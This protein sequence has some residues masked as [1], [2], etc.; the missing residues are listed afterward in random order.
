[1]DLSKTLLI[2]A[3]SAHK[4][5]VSFLCICFL[6]RSTETF[7]KEDDLDSLINEIF[8]EPNLDKKPSVSQVL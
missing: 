8:E 4:P 1:M 3:F 6:F 5:Q 2:L 7:K